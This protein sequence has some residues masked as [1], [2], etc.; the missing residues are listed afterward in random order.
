M[1]IAAHWLAD[2]G[3]AKTYSTGIVQKLGD[4]CKGKIKSAYKFKWKYKLI[5]N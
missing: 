2:N 4:C 1:T 3:Y 5:Y